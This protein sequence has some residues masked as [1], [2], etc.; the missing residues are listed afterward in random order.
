M[1]PARARRL[2]AETA[3]L[4]RKELRWRGAHRPSVWLHGFLSESATLYDFETHG[5]SDY[6]SD[7][8]RQART[9]EI[10]A[11][12]V[13]S[14]LNNKLAFHDRMAAEG[15]E[16]S[17]VDLLG[18]LSDDRFHSFRGAGVSLKRLLRA[19][20][21]IVVKPVS[22]GGG[23]GVKIIRVTDEGFDVNGHSVGFKGVWSRL[24]RVQPA[25]VE[26][27]AR[28]HES[29]DSLYPAT[30]NT[31]RLL[32]LRDVDTHEPYIA[33]GVLRVGTDTSFPLDNWGR[34][35]LSCSIDLRTGIVGAGAR[36][37]KRSELTWH[38]THPDTGTLLDGA[39]VP[40]WRE[41]KK[42]VRR[43]T[44]RMPYLQ[45]VGWDVVITGEGPR[46]LEGNSYSGVRLFQVHGPLLQDRRVRAFYREHGV[47]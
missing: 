29:L 47:I 36:F 28:Q 32:T 8:A 22:D 35:G 15:L 40:H 31:L 5:Y 18:L 33:A 14:I 34:G 37:P 42:L 6:L 25:V 7:Y 26:R 9:R 41:T 46:I 44:R 19:E 23:N 16:D 30:V 27:L 3:D 13:R 12:G 11:P 17:K 43:V 4:R 2:F 39:T 38:T 1:R 20:G 24:K 21:A 10:N 45:Y